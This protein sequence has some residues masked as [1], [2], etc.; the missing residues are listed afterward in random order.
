MRLGGG[1]ETHDECVDDFSCFS[2]GEA[3]A[4]KRSGVVSE[5][6]CEK[7]SQGTDSDDAPVPWALHQMLEELAPRRKLEHQIVLARRLVPF[8]RLDD[9]RVLEPEKRV[10]PEDLLFVVTDLFLGND[11]DRD[12]SAR[13]RPEDGSSAERREK[14]GERG[15]ASGEGSARRSSSFRPAGEGLPG[16]K[17]TTVA[18]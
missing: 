12:L 3:V 1:D 9:V 8:Y 16:Q 17:Q 2:F 4:R 5:L 14:R 15:R 11:L 6:D 13:A 18:P 10:L 7:V